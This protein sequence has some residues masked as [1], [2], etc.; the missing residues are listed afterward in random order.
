M[1]V[2]Y[3]YH[4]GFAVETDNFKLI[5]DFYKTTNYNVGEF[6]LEKF[7]DGDK[8]IIVFSSHSHG[9]HFN[10]EILNWRRPDRNISYVLSDDINIKEKDENIHFI[11]SNSSLEL[12]VIKIK[13]FDST[14]EGVSFYVECDN[15]T[16]FHCGDL[17]WW[18]W[19]DD[20][21]EEIQYMKNYYTEIV[22]NIQRRVD[23]KIDFLFYPVDPRLEDNMFLGVT[24]FIENINVDKIIPMHFWNNFNVIKQLQ[25]KIKGR[26]ES[27]VYFDENMS[28]IL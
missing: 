26:K 18:Y 23:K 14:D 2:Y 11:E 4:S 27:V 13:T 8:K 6:D 21:L 1:K 10:P 20:T 15:Y 28:R 12:D 22:D 9:D 17:N 3:I 25:E 24:Y 7:L 16:F 19:P 5:F